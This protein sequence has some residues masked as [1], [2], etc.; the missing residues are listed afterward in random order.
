[1]F[2]SGARS[3]TSLSQ[4]LRFTMLVTVARGPMSVTAFLPRSS[5]ASCIRPESGVKS[6]T[7]LFNRLRVVRL[8]QY[9]SAK[10]SRT[11]KFAAL[12][13]VNDSRST[14]VIGPS[15]SPSATR[16][17]DSSPRVANLDFHLAHGA[18]GKNEDTHKGHTRQP[19]PPHFL[20]DSTHRSPLI[21]AHSHHGFL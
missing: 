7:A 9:C 6:L 15:G 16:R 19:C 12:S 4:R 21:A 11:A 2:A 10:R 13:S 14:S 20:P 8:T 17:A 5:T 18:G 3:L 1:M